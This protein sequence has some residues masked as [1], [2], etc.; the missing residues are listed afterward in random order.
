MIVVLK[1]QKPAPSFW[2]FLNCLRFAGFFPCKKVTYNESPYARL[3]P[4]QWPIQLL[5][6]LSSTLIMIVSTILA[7]YHICPDDVNALNCFVDI[8]KIGAAMEHSNFDFMVLMAIY[9]CVFAI[10]GCLMVGLVSFKAKL[11]EVHDCTLHQS[12]ADPSMTQSLK[13][14][15]NQHVMTMLVILLGWPCFII[16]YSMNIIDSLS[17]DVIDVIPLVIWWIVFILWCFGPLF[18]FHFYFLEVSLILYSWILSLKDKII[19]NHPFIYL[20]DDC[21]NMLKCLQMFSE[22][23]TVML[24][25]L[26]TMI[27]LFAIIEVYLLIAFFLSKDNI[28]VGITFNICGYGFFGIL[29]IYFAHIYCTF[30]QLFKDHIES[31]KNL[32]ADIDLNEVQTV[33]VIDGKRQSIRHVK[34]RI[35]AGLEGFHG[36]HGNGYFTLGK[37]LFSSITANFITYLI[38]LVQF[39]VS[40]MS[41]AK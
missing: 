15:L 11:C 25:W 8:Q 35:V 34:E 5:C 7:F 16:G 26:F 2:P 9:G 19:K 31:I 32:I 4:I 36:F 18:S 40:E 23:I 37:P 30:S 20:L 28:T 10:H 27:L 22:S 41:S 17:V 6:Y 33:S 29:F 12:G 13:R 24:F 39:K 38:I 1:D 3:V 14:K 21:K